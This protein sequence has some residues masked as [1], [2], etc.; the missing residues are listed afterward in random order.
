MVKKEMEGTKLAEFEFPVER[1]KIKEF[2]SAILD[3]NPIYRDREYARSKGFNDVLMPVTF[4]GSFPHHLDSDNFI[5]E[6][7]LK[8]GVDP[9][10]GVLGETEI[11]HHRPVCAGETLR[12]EI[13]IGRIYEKEGKRGGKMTFIELE[14]H[15][16]DAEN[17]PVVI[18]RNT[19]IEQG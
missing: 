15:Y 9:T 17:N 8:I 6:L 7:S 16:Y 14:I 1:G 2:A 19:T 13:K 12:G 5:L 3:P 11:I 4:P 10:K 18:M